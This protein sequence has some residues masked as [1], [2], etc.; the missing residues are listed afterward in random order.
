MK[1]YIISSSLSASHRLALP[2]TPKLKEKSSNG[3]GLEQGL[4]HKHTLTHTCCPFPELWKQRVS[5][6]WPDDIDFA[7]KETA[8]QWE[9]A[10]RKAIFSQTPYF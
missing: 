1:R 7:Q 9:G 8:G 4:D 2:D 3:E 10:V 6:A 5:P